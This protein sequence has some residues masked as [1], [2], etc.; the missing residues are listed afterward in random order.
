M[1][2]NILARSGS[3]VRKNEDHEGSEEHGWIQ[4][5]E[6]DLATGE[7]EVVGEH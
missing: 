3:A 7:L 5:V 1:D 2:E 6:V 4:V